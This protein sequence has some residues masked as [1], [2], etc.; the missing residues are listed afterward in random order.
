MFHN[1]D[2]SGNLLLYY[3]ISEIT[4]LLNINKNK[5]VKQNLLQFI[6]RYIIDI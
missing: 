1:Y 3:F 5:I 4:K 6:V 2:Y